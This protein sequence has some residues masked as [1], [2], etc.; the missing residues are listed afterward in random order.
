MASELRRG[1]H[2]KRYTSKDAIPAVPCLC[3]AL[4]S[5]EALNCAQPSNRYPQT[6][7]YLR[8]ET[9]GSCSVPSLTT[10]LVE[11]LAVPSG[12]EPSL[13]RLL[14]GLLTWK[15]KITISPHQSEAQIEHTSLT[16]GSH[17]IW[18]RQRASLPYC[19]LEVCLAL[20]ISSLLDSFQD[21]FLWLRP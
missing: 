1:C 18:P 11:P 14:S 2:L 10:E 9:L 7:I 3:A 16:L 21:R 12:V 5:Q 4:R 8:S 19:C 20:G 6:L 15:M 17:R 13:V